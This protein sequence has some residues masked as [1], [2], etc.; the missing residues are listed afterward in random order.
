MLC[1]YADAEA[2]DF[3]GFLNML[4]V[5]SVDSL[6][7]YDDRAGILAS[8]ASL[9]HI[10][11]LLDASYH[12]SDHSG[13]SSHHGKAFLA[14]ISRS[15][16]AGVSD[17][18]SHADKPW[19]KP[20]VKFNFD[21]GWGPTAPAHAAKPPETQGAPPVG[22]ITSGQGIE[23]PALSTATAAKE[24]GGDTSNS[25]SSCFNNG[26]VRGGGHFDRRMHGASLYHNALLQAPG[27]LGAGLYHANM[28][29]T[30]AE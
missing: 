22:P 29:A 10:S 18:G 19:L 13:G 12:G 16:Q 28:L 20:Q 17:Q 7:L 11:A 26:T 24:N 21:F 27:K 9:D 5:G 3:D 6:D 23:L 25:T 2:M 15:N 1:L 8:P 14:H 30:V 4:K